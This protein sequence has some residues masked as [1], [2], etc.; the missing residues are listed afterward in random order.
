MEIQRIFELFDTL[1]EQDPQRGI[2]FN[3]QAEKKTAFNAAECVKKRDQIS[4]YLLN[5]FSLESA[6]HIGILSYRGS[7]EWLI[8]DLAI[9]QIGMIPVPIHSNYT[10]EEMRFVFHHASIDICFVSNLSLY[11]KIHSFQLE[12]EVHFVLLEE[13]S[14]S[15]SISSCFQKEL[16]SNDIKRIQQEREKIQSSDLCTI[17]YTSGSSGDPKGV[18]LSHQN[19]ISNIQSTISLLPIK[20]NQIAVSFLPMSHI[21]ERMVSYSYLSLGLQLHFIS[22]SDKILSTVKEIRPH[23]FTVVPRILENIYDSILDQENSHLFKQKL[24]EWAFKV[25]ERYGKDIKKSILY[26][27]QLLLVKQL[28]FKPWRKIM[29]GRVKGIMVGAAALEAKIGRLFSAA[30]M[31]V[32]EGYGMTETSPVISFNRFE[33]RKNKFGTVGLP[34]SNVEVKIAKNNQEELENN[35]GE[36]WVKGPN[37]MMGYYKNETLT[38][39][40]FSKDGWFKTGDMGSL[41]TQGFLK[42]H[43]RQKNYFKTS[44]GRF[45]APVPIEQKLKSLAYVDQVLVLGFKRPSVGALIVPDLVKLKKW[46]EKENIHWTAPKYMLINLKVEEFYQQLIQEINTSLKKHEKIEVFR[47]MEE[48]WTLENGL[49]TPSLKLKRLKIK[50]L[51]QKTIDNMYE[52]KL[53]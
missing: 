51:H 11:E 7:A 49:L 6:S 5:N 23:Y 47:L 44:S 16:D 22:N 2:L 20:E 42:I 50:E 45:V 37:I 14:S 13:N 33:R 43:D 39:Q 41:D 34:V 46:A 29:G 19:I 48:A 21:F 26:S 35:V 18:M 17:I 8:S 25:G 3:H 10:E 36:I 12:R 40:S 31:P 38:Q 24:L 1:H 27:F 30:G 53:Q 9:Q 28:V 32:R 4:A 15:N 52:S